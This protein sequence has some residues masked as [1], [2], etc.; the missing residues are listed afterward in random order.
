MITYSQNDTY[1]NDYEVFYAFHKN[2][3]IY[4]DTFKMWEQQGKIHMDTDVHVNN[5]REDD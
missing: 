1:K 2:D 5:Q 4:E 3:S